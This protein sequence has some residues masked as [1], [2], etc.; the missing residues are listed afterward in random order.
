MAEGVTATLTGVRVVEHQS[1]L[2]LLG[3]DLLRGGRPGEWN[4]AGI[5][6]TTMGAGMVEGSLEFTKGEQV[7]RNSRLVHYPAAGGAKFM[8]TIYGQGSGLVAHMLG[9]MTAAPQHV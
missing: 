7:F 5:R 9:S 1:P 8:S 6:Q 3:S 4:F 2:L